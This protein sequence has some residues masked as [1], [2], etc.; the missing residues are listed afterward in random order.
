MD[1]IKF[2]QGAI[3]T[4]SGPEKREIRVNICRSCEDEGRFTT[5]EGNTVSWSCGEKWSEI[6]V[7]C[8]NSDKSGGMESGVVDM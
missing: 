7:D 5:L 8:V 6:V 2:Q 4:L 1:R 3:D